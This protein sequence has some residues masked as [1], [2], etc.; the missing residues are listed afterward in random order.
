MNTQGH[1]MQTQ[2]EDNE[3]FEAIKRGQYEL[4]DQLYLHHRDA[5]VTYAQ[6]QLSA[7]EEDAV[8]CFQDS[9]IAFYKNVVSGRLTELRC[10]I[11]TY[12]FSIG[13]RLV[14][15]RNHQRRR[16]PPTDHESGSNPA[17]ELDWSLIDRFEEQHNRKLLQSAMDQ[18]GSPCREIL[19]LYYFHHY[20]IESI[21]Q[22]VGLPSPGA[23]RIKKMRCLQSLKQLVNP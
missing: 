18:L 5:F 1:R 8:D 4:I 12:L 2:T 7:T 13:K 16:E 6:R 3:L 23:T 22:S 15:R 14:Y 19:T 17:D 21:T 10:T 9:V 20:P 11:R